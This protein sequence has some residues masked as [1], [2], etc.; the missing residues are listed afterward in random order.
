MKIDGNKT[1]RGQ[2]TCC[3]T[4]SAKISCRREIS[5]T[6]PSICLPSCEKNLLTSRIKM[7]RIAYLW[8][9]I[10]YPSQSDHFHPRIISSYLWYSPAATVIISPEKHQGCLEG[11]STTPSHIHIRASL[12]LATVSSN[13]F[14]FTHLWL[15]SD[16]WLTSLHPPG[17]S[18]HSPTSGS[19]A[20]TRQN[21]TIIKH[22]YFSGNRGWD[23]LNANLSKRCIQ[24]KML[25]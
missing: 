19:P 5:T 8:P 1:K 23:C 13:S 16:A 6:F 3:R 14:N 10:L 2:L 15:S 25:N 9:S 22:C 4:F 17:C 20:Q 11:K 21:Q 18:S 7:L 24:Q 12:D